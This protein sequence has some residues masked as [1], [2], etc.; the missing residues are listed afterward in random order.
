MGVVSKT[1]EQKPEYN[2]YLQEKIDNARKT[3]RVKVS[4]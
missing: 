4:Y 1:K 3:I 2:D